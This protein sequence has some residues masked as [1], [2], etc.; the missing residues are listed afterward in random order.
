MRSVPTP[1]AETAWTLAVNGEA[2]GRGTASP[3]DATDLAVGLSFAEGFLREPGDLLGVDVRETAHGVILDVQVRPQRFAVALEERQH[4]ID[5]GCG[6]LHAVACN[7]G[8]R[9]PSAIAIPADEI[10]ADHLRGLFDACRKSHPAGGVHA[11][12]IVSEA[13][14][15]FRRIDVSRHAAVDKVIGA[16]YVSGNAP[17]A[18]GLVI[19]AR[20]SGRMADTATRAGIT[21]FASR[22]VPTTLALAIA[23]ATG[24]TLIARAGAAEVHR[25][26]PPNGQATA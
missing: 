18:H 13:G 4:R 8:T 6:L 10:L 23:A 16:A 21:W 14:I 15:A 19:T 1:V 7:P 3:G 17:T 25:F 9:V 5:E 24:L 26:T 11:A 12:A 20:I 2:V 22:S